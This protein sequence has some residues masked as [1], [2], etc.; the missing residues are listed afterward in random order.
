MY[1]LCVCLQ[2]I[3]VYE[4]RMSKTIFYTGSTTSHG[5][6]T[7]YIHPYPLLLNP[8]LL[9]KNFHVYDSGNGTK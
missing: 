1:V 5:T 3:Y 9:Q 8:F 2:G 6:C 4:L 7:L